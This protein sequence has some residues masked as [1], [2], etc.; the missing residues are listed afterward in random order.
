M[1]SFLPVLT[2]IFFLIACSKPNND[3]DSPDNNNNNNLDYTIIPDKSTITTGITGYMMQYDSVNLPGAV[4]C[5]IAGPLPTSGMWLF[6]NNKTD[7][8]NTIVGGGVGPGGLYVPV[9]RVIPVSTSLRN[10]FDIN[11][12]TRTTIGSVYE[13]TAGN[14][15]FPKGGSL[16]GTAGS[17]TTISGGG[18]GFHN[19]ECSYLDP[20]SVEFGVRLTRFDADVDGKR[21]YLKSYGSM[22]IEMYTWKVSLVNDI[23]MELAVPASMLAQAPDSIQAWYLNT[24]LNTGGYNWIKKGIAKKTAIG[25]RYK[26]DNIGT[27]N[28]AVP[29]KGVYSVI[30]LR[31]E[32]GIPIVNT[33]AVI[34]N[35]FG[36]LASARS[37]AD[38]N[39]TCFLPVNEPISIEL[40]N[41][42]Y[43]KIHDIIYTKALDPIQSNKPVEVVVPDNSA[44]LRSIKGSVKTCAGVALQQGVVTIRDRNGF[45]Y[46]DIPV[47]NGQ[48]K[49]AITLSNYQGSTFWLRATYGSQAG[50]DS[51]I[52]LTSASSKLYTYDITNCQGATGLSATYSVDEGASKT[53]SSDAVTL[54]GAYLRG[55]FNHNTA[56]TS[57]YCTQNYDGFSFETYAY[58]PGTNGGISNLSV[59][60]KSVARDYSKPGKLEI[61]RYDV[62]APGYIEGKLDA[63]YIDAAN[64]SHHLVASFRVKRQS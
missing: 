61:T 16:T 63:Y 32:S 9:S 52:V 48:Y 39:V 57:I 17:F 45:V 44:W 62:M 4:Y 7:P 14:W 5:N 8:Y 53:L 42:Y 6:D 51:A 47:V 59:N 1:K 28:F 54:S 27:W 18:T 12:K 55:I 24:D 22:L 50:S 58:Q 34:K 33:R 60:G 31:T 29:V 56:I 15:T 46:A 10:Y 13:K 23:T 19:V 41:S 40:R 30:K 2:A 37:D 26:I 21:W 20:T 11:L 49:A 36:E 64:V 3:P 35:Q 43:D 25:Y 38:G